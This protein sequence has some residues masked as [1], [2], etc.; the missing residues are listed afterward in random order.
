M[1]NE[2]NAQNMMETPDAPPPEE[3]NNRTFRIVAGVM[4]GLVFLTLVCMAIYFLVLRPRSTA[5]NSATQV[6][7]ET[8]NAQA[9]QKV[10][11]TAQA[12]MWTPTLPPTPITLK[13]STSIPKTPTVSPTPVIA[14]GTQ[15]AIATTNPAMVIAMQTQLAIQM[16]STAAALPTTT[17]GVQGMPQTGFFD[18]VGLPSMIILAIALVVIIFL[19]RRIRKSPAK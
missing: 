2:G 8:Q 10:T 19:A 3:K 16:T 12:A 5:Q 18:D 4:A 1:L 11:L 6:A 13:T 17:L 9:I 7:I 15:A 14:L